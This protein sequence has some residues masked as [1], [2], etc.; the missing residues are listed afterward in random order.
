MRVPPCLRGC[1]YM[2]KI[3]ADEYRSCEHW[4]MLRQQRTNPHTRTR[5]VREKSSHRLSEQNQVKF[6]D[7]MYQP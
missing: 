6:T 4:Q 5:A 2:S 1:C 7:E 3:A